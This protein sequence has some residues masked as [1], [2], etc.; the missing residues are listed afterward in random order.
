MWC[1]GPEP[2]PHL[3]GQLLDDHELVNRS[4]EQPT[5]LYFILQT[6]SDLKE[7]DGVSKLEPSASQSDA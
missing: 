5:V 3:A 2:H 4:F 6:L 7:S 1:R